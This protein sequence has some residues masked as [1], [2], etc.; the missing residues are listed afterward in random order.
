LYCVFLVC[1]VA[2]VPVWWLVCLIACLI[3]CASVIGVAL[4][5]V[6][7]VNM[8]SCYYLFVF[9]PNSAKGGIALHPGGGYGRSFHH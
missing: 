7:L 1:L 9:S 3:V 6:N 2:C 4:L 8:G 5:H